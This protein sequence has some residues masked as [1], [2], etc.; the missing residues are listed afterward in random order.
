VP[1]ADRIAVFDNDGTLWCEKPVPIQVDFVF[2]RIAKQG[3]ENPSLCDEQPWKAVVEKDY[4]WLGNVITKH[5]NGDDRD[6]KTYGSWTP[7]SLCR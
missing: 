6:L 7:A 5:Y 1:P 4:K 2:R 3:E